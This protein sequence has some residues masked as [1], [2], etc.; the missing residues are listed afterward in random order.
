VTDPDPEGRED[1][2]DGLSVE[3]PISV[4][5]GGQRVQCGAEIT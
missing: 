4:E 2:G 5:G 1:A 3:R